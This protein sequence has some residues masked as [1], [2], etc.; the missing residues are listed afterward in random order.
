M[1]TTYIEYNPINK[2]LV[3]N[4]TRKLYGPLTILI[5]MVH[6]TVIS[7]YVNFLQSCMYANKSY[8]SRHGVAGDFRLTIPVKLG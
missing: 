2:Y 7:F 1:F 6:I 8:L 4:R 5:K 3:L